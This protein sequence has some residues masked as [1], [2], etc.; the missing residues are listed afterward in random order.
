VY[1][2]FGTEGSSQKQW[3]CAPWTA[4]GGSLDTK[5]FAKELVA[6]GVVLCRDQNQARAACFR[7][8]PRLG[9][10]RVQNADDGCISGENTQ[11]DGCDDGHE[12]YGGH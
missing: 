7:L 4:E 3:N 10:K 1:S 12:E 2:E 11:A 9:P 5:P 6:A 8:L